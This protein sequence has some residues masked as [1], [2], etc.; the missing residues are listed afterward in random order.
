MKINER[1][2]R[3]EDDYSKL[4]NFVEINYMN[5]E[6]TEECWR[7]IQ[8]YVQVISN[9]SIKI[10]TILTLKYLHMYNDKKR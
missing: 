3:K 6:M 4:N 1:A 10:F 2:W 8:Y 9:I 7:Y 5:S